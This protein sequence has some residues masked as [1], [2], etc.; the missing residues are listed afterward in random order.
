LLELGGLLSLSNLEDSVN[1]PSQITLDGAGNLWMLNGCTYYTDD[2]VNWSFKYVRQFDSAGNFLYAFEHPDFRANMY[3]IEVDR[4]ANEIY[5]SNARYDKVMVFDPSGNFLREFG[6]TGSGPGQFLGP[7]GV[8]VDPGSDSVFVIDSGNQ[9]IQKFDTG[10]NFVMLI[11]SAGSGPGAFN[12]RANS[13]I[14]LDEYG[15]LLRGP[16]Q[17]QQSTD[18]RSGGPLH[19]RYR[20]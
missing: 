9:R 12:F 11:G 10:G 15:H 18:V 16:Q 2:P 14:T 5:V 8:A 3:G 1:L 7:A 17:Q 13:G 6:G 20:V 4:V 19:R